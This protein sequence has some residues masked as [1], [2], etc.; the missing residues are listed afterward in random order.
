MTHCDNQFD[1]DFIVI[2]SGFGGSVSAL[3]LVEKGYQVAVMEMGR[4]W[5]PDNSAAHQLVHPSLVLA[6]QT[7]PAWLLQHPVLQAR[8]HLPWLC[9]RWRIHHLR[10]HLASSSRESVGERARGRDWPIGRRKCRSTTKLPRGCWVSR[11]TDPRTC[12]PSPEESC[13]SRGMRAHFLLHES[14]HLPAQQGEPGNQIFP[15][16]FFGGEGPARTTCIACGGCMMGCRYGAKNTLDLSY[17]VSGGK[18]RAHASFPKPR[19]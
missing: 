2:G 17:S 5:T 15:D 9:G 19:W 8:N 18:A 14:G 6:S 7:R 12:R 3:R 11:K 10:L 1:F 16:P 13:R 4:R